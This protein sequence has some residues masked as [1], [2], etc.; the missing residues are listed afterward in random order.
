[1]LN[2]YELMIF[3]NTEQESR[4]NGCNDPN[5]P[6]HDFPEHGTGESDG[7]LILFLSS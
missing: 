1:M 3:P 7:R 6:A 2:F 4:R 5:C